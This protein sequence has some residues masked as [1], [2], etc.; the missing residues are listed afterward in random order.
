MIYALAAC[1]LMFV[2]NSKLHA[3]TNLL[4]FIAALFLFIVIRHFFDYKTAQNDNKHNSGLCQ[5]GQQRS[6]DFYKDCDSTGI[7]LMQQ[8]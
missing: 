7:E 2:N 8:V 4:A 6:L 5:F 1:L 3:T